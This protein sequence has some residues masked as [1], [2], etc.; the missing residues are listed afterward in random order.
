MLQ[1]GY[2]AKDIILPSIIFIPNDIESSLSSRTNY[3]GISLFNAVEKVF[4]YAIL[5]VSNNVLRH[6]ICSLVLTLSCPEVP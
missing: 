6:W 4:D 3:G 2:N 1:H 5:M